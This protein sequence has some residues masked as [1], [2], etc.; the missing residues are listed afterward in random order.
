MQSEEYFRVTAGGLEVDHTYVRN[1]PLKTSP[2]AQAF[3]VLEITPAG[4]SIEWRATEKLRDDKQAFLPYATLDPA[5][6]LYRLA[7]YQALVNSGQLS[8][9]H[10]EQVHTKIMQ[11][12]A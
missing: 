11:M 9:G 7:D 12:K 6:P 2:Y 8:P 3:R 10:N 4:I 5:C 1:W